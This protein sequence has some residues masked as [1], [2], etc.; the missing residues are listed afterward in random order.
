MARGIFRS[1]WHLIVRQPIDL[2]NSLPGSYEIYMKTFRWTTW[3][4]EHACLP[5]TLIALSKACLAARQPTSWKICVLTKQN[6]AFRQLEVPFTASPNRLASQMQMHFG[7]RFIGGSEQSRAVPLMASIQIPW[8][9]PPTARWQ[10]DR[11]RQKSACKPSPQNSSER[12][13]E[14]V[15]AVTALPYDP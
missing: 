1:R 5:V 7:V 2:Q 3:H 13:S 15:I 10:R 9:F 14:G 11:R 8:R 4:G 6:V 12:F